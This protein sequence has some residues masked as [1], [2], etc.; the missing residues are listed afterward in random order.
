MR[1]DRLVPA[2]VGLAA[3]FGVLLVAVDVDDGA[4]AS[5]ATPSSTTSADPITT[6]GESTASLPAESTWTSTATTTTKIRPTTTTTVRPTTTTTSTL[7]A[8]P[9]GRPISFDPRCVGLDL[10]EGA[11]IAASPNDEGLLEL[12]RRV[13]LDRLRDETDQIGEADIEDV[14]E[15]IS[16]LDLERCDEI[17]ADLYS[18]DE[19]GSDDEWLCVF[20]TS[21]ES[22]GD[23]STRTIEVGVCSAPERDDSTTTQPERSTTTA[24]GRGS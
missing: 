7:L 23:L 18:D 9:S 3:G 15:L 10:G 19:S 12:V 17:V 13:V 8:N 14:S 21:I 16:S 4:D 11:V 1:L 22:S 5:T 20:A 24:P 6:L 2:L